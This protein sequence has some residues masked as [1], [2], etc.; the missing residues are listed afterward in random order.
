MS[1]IIPANA[2]KNLENEMPSGLINRTAWLYAH[3]H[4]ARV[5]LDVHEENSIVSI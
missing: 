4:N 2:V 3:Y 5:L 1:L